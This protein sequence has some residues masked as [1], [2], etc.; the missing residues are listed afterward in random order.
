[1]KA[2]RRPLFTLLIALA[3]CA[4][5]TPG[6]Y[7]LQTINDEPLPT[8]FLDSEIMAAEIQLNDDGTCLITSTERSESGVVTTGSDENCTWTSNGAAIT[9]TDSNGP[10]TG[11]VAD[12]RLTLTTQG[13]V[14]VLV[15]R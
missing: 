13:V 10:L 4:T 9:V 15:Q 12:D 11:S 14:F 8:R 6:R 7:G 5:A 2:L 3:A 1:M